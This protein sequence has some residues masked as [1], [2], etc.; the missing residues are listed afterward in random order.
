MRYSI[1]QKCYV[2]SRLGEGLARAI[3]RQIG[4]RDAKMLAPKIHV[5]ARLKYPDPETEREARH[6]LSVDF[7]QATIANP[8]QH[9]V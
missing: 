9:Y 4:K 7:W 3:L 2:A 6:N 5:V 8:P 1:S